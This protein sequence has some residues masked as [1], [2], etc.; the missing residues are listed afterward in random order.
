MLWD[1]GLEIEQQGRLIPAF[2]YVMPVS[3]EVYFA[4]LTIL[5]ARPSVPIGALQVVLD[6]WLRRRGMKEVERGAGEERVFIP[7]GHPLPDLEQPMIGIG[8]A[9]SQVHPATGY[10]FARSLRTAER[11]ADAVA[12]ARNETAVQ[13]RAALWRAVWPEQEVRS[14]AVYELGLEA[15]LGMGA[16]QTRDFFQCFF[17]LPDPLWR[18]YLAG[19]LHGGEL[20]EAMW[21]LFRDVP[22][23]LKMELART[24]IGR[25][26]PEIV[27]A[28]RG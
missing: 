9:A 1:N 21:M 13:A 17:D 8:G 14:R 20:A 2:L 15:V 23:A 12:E 5:A 11:L 22:I 7:M 25:R 6:D 18:G 26:T 10:M 24:A 28:L 4:E 16:A 27:R 3:C 19:S